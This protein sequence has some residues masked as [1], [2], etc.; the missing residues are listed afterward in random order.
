MG[1]LY[2]VVIKEGLIVDHA[3]WIGQ[4]L[5]SGWTR[6]EITRTSKTNSYFITVAKNLQIKVL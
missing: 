4:L 1:S 3:E 5:A 6:E 2:F